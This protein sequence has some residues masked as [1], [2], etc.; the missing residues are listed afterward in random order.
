MRLLVSRR[1]AS[2]HPFPKGSNSD[3]VRIESVYDAIGQLRSPVMVG[4]A[5]IDY[6]GPARDYLCE[7]CMTDGQIDALVAG[8]TA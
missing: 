2:S 4:L 7:G 3:D 1:F 8:L 6:A 5:G